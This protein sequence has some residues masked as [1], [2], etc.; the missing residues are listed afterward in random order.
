MTK[1]ALLAAGGIFAVCAL[2]VCGGDVPEKPGEYGL[3]LAAPTIV[4]PSGKRVERDD[5]PGREKRAQVNAEEIWFANRY[6]LRPADGVDP[7]ARLPLRG[8]YVAQFRGPIL[9]E[10]REALEASGARVL[11]YVQN[12]AYIIEVPEA[13][14]SDVAALAQSGLLRYLGPYPAEARIAWGLQQA[15][16]SRPA[17]EDIEITARFFDVPSKAQKEAVSDILAVAKWEDDPVMPFARGSVKPGQLRRIAGLPFVKWV[18]EYVPGEPHN[19]EG[20]MS[21]GADRVVGWGTYDGTGIRVAVDDSGITRTGTKAECGVAGAAYHPDLGSGRIADQWDFENNDSNA[22]DDDGHGTHTAGS[23]G[24]DGTNTS[25]WT[26]IAPGVTFLIYKDCCDN[27]GFGFG[28]F[29]DVLTQAAL[30]DANV[31]ANSWGGGNNDYN[32]A[33]EAADNA[34]RGNWPGS[35]ASPQYMNVT[36]SSGNDNDLCSRPGTG[37]NVIAVGAMRDGNWPYEGNDWCWCTNNG[38]CGA[39]GC[40]PSP[41]CGPDNYWPPTGRICFSNYGPVDTDGDGN[42][43]IKPD[44]VAPG[45]RITSTAAVHMES[46]ADLID[47][48]Y[49]AYD[50]T[51]MSQPM[52]AGTVALMLD[53]YPG[54]ED[55]P[56]RLKARLLATAVDLGNTDFYGHG[57][58]DALH[59]VYDSSSLDTALWA[60]STI[61]LTGEEDDH[62]FTVSAGFAEVRVYLTWSDPA[63]TTTEVVNDLNLRVYDDTAALVGSSLSL[64]DT[65]EYVRLTSGAAGSWRANVRGENVPQP[66][67]KYGIIAVVV[68]N[69]PSR[70]LSASASAACL[71]PGQTFTI[72]TTHSNTG[73][74]VVGSQIQLD[75]PDNPLLFPLLDVDMTTGD[76]G[77]GHTFLESEL[78]RDVPSNSYYLATG[79]VNQDVPRSATWNLQVDSGTADGTYD[80][81]VYATAARESTISETVTVTVDGTEPGAVTDLDSTSHTLDTCSSDMSVTMTWT[82]ALDGTGCGIDGYGIWWSVSAHGL[83]SAVKDIE[84]V[85]TYTET[86]AP[87]VSP[88]YFNI[89]S[90]DNAGNWASGYAWWGPFYLNVAPTAAITETC[91]NPNS[92]LDADPTGGTPPYTYLWSTG[93]TTETISAPC[94]TGPYTVTVT[95]ALGCSDTSAPVNTCPCNGGPLPEPDPVTAGDAKGNTWMVGNHDP[96]TTQYYVYYNPLTSF[97][98]ALADDRYD[99]GATVAN[100]CIAGWIDNL[101]GTA[102]VTPTVGL[103]NSWLL[104]TAATGSPG[105]ESTVG[106]DSAATERN[107]V[108]TWA[109]MCGP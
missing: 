18:E 28:N 101:D 105:S 80:F 19:I 103:D 3:R 95:G 32:W 21:G 27:K 82:A 31:V 8:V 60:G 23:I 55:W 15:A 40:T 81:Y 50:G 36:V 66:D 43:R 83:P 47:G 58:V 79:I 94:G 11:D 85:T 91:G 35:D 102:T 78:W 90:V 104:V 74:S 93:A 86:L 68:L 69:A 72:S 56:E 52:A 62:I 53:A 5:G 100:D 33:S 96:A 64:D 98:Q 73:Y 61:T 41:S 20:S 48:F 30:N 13:S 42:Y 9:K 54:L 92:V 88:Y 4:A 89:R 76:A 84:E 14:S 46:P 2:P 12:Y 51:S 108:G 99:N 24:G 25:D 38:N 67:Q 70:S 65:V 26:G 107:T 45:T 63:T 10:W 49:V 87:S 109:P 16:K 6:S 77:R 39:K 44:V 37:K 97:G 106:V 57:M 22:C 71:Q 75:M 34:V 17:G 1:R 59:A 29:T 7:E